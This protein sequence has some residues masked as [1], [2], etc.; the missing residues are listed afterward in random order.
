K[1]EA[2]RRAAGRSPRGAGHDY[3]TA[4]PR[5]KALLPG[6]CRQSRWLRRLGQSGPAQ[7]EDAQRPAVAPASAPPGAAPARGGTSRQRRPHSQGQGSPRHS[8]KDRRESAVDTISARVLLATN[9]LALFGV[10]QEKG[11]AR[12][13]E[14]SREATRMQ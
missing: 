13:K 6:L 8:L 3:G 5:R 1:K 9:N 2:G 12:D 7:A 11:T 10:L 14:G 4:C